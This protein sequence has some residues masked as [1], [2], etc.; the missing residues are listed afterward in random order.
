MR[1]SECPLDAA[2][3]RVRFMPCHHADRH[4][5]PLVS[6]RPGRYVPHANRT[7]RS[8][9]MHLNM[10]RPPRTVQSF[11]HFIPWLP[12]S[13]SA[14]FAVNAT[15]KS[16][17]KDK[18]PTTSSETATARKD[19]LS[20]SAASSQSASTNS[21]PS[22]IP[23]IPPTNNPR[24][25][26][27]FSSKVD[28]AF[29]EGY[30]RYRAAFERRREEKMREQHA[31]N[32]WLRWVWGGGGGAG[33]VGLS[34]GATGVRT[35]TLPSH[36]LRR[37]PGRSTLSSTNDASITPLNLSRSS[38]PTLASAPTMGS[39]AL[40]GPSRRLRSSARRPMHHQSSAE[41][42]GTTDSDTSSIQDVPAVAAS[43]SS[44]DA[45]GQGQPP[46][47][48]RRGHEKTESYSFILGRETGAQVSP[49]RHAPSDTSSG[50]RRSL[51]GIRW[52]L[53][54]G[55]EDRGEVETIAEERT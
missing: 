45:S 1:T 9:N 52:G 42:V 6:H 20:S 47:P 4:A 55:N 49:D 29:R 43:S 35:P 26:L 34:G 7:L 39:N 33:S 11:L 12:R 16:S 51:A 28:K 5:L 10:R 44:T 21:A 41:S 27:I 31:R 54:G 48:L 14:A 17:E 19:S 3:M 24:G 38:T 36:G 53:G 22:V 50:A 37:V 23:P 18:T 15:R 40:D 32:S 13:S 46:S 2:R 30:E 8:I 25:E